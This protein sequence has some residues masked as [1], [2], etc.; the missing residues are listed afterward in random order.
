VPIDI[1]T[2]RIPFYGISNSFLNTIC[3]SLEV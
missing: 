1:S 3:F 2:S